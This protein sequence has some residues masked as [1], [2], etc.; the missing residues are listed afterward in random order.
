MTINKPE[1]KR[2]APESGYDSVMRKIN[3][4]R[5]VEDGCYVR[6]SDY[7]RLQ[8]ECADIERDYLAIIEAQDAEH[9]KQTV[10]LQA[11]CESLR[12]GLK[13]ARYR[14]EQG[15]IWNGMGWSLTGLHAYQQQQALDEI[16]AALSQ[17][18]ATP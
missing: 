14:I 17:K 7:E 13:N 3:W 1:V 16:D 9:R 15:R 6:L 8:A 2:Y 10:K 12:N 5:E 18:D 11:E 4:M